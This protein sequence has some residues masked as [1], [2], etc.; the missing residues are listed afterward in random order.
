MLPATALYAYAALDAGCPFVDFTPSLAARPGAVRARAR[1]RR[2]LRRQ[3]RQDR[4]DADQDRARPGFAGR[5]LRVRSWTGR[6]CS[7]AATVPRS[8][9]PTRPRASSSRRA[10]PRGDPRLRGRGAGDDRERAE[11]GEWKTAW[12]HIS[13]EGFLGTRMRMQFTWEGCDSALAAPLVLD[14]VAARRLGARGRGERAAAAARL[15]LQ[16]SGRDGRAP[17]GA[18]FAMLVDWARGSGGKGRHEARAPALGDVAELVRL[19]AVLTVPG[20]VLLGR[21][22]SGRPGGRGAALGICLGSSLQYLA[23]MALND[24]ADRELDAAERPGRPLPSGRVTAGF[25]L[26]LAGLLRRPGSPARSRG[27]R[28]ARRRALALAATVWAYDLA[29]KKAL[30]PGPP[31]MAAARFL[32]VLDGAA[33]GRARRCR[34]RRSSAPTRCRHAR[35]PRGGA[36][37]TPGSGR[38]ALAATGGRVRRGRQRSRPAQSGRPSPAGAPAGLLAAYAASIG[39]APAH[40][41]RE[42]TPRTSSAW[43]APGCSACCRSQA[44]LLVASGGTAAAVAVTGAW[45]LA[46]ALARRGR[47]REPA[48]RLRDQRPRRTTGSTTRSRCSPTADTTASR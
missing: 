41:A 10:A 34:R 47:S 1:T 17:A 3:R 15:L 22:D 31:A 18:Q 28:T 45:P 38:G 46:R 39:A 35:Q 44:A 13:F 25:A 9:T 42:P 40:G 19:P 23:G 30:P 20:D 36:G 16:G 27:G 2:A 32:D 8:P 5:A 24:Y 37:G 29:L 4:R 26:G 21:G 48:A 6:I 43:S 33:D 12:D 14:L 11:L 7:A